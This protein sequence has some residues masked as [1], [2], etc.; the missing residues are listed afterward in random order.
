MMMTNRK[1]WGDWCECVGG[2]LVFV[3]EDDILEEVNTNP[4]AQLLKEYQKNVKC[5]N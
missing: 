5:P 3:E 2:A 1:K 4:V